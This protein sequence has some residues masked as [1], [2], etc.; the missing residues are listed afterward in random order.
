MWHRL[1]ASV[2]I[3]SVLHGA[4]L[5]ESKAVALCPLCFVPSLPDNAQDVVRRGQAGNGLAWMWFGWPLRPSPCSFMWE[6]GS[7]ASKQNCL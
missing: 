1:M 7:A 4:R 2:L 5:G 3:L 6:R